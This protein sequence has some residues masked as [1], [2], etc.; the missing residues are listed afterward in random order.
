MDLSILIVS[1]KTKDYLQKCL[2]SIFHSTTKYSFE[3]ILV[4]NNSQDGTR[5]MLLDFFPNI[6]T[7]YNEENT[8]FAIAMN[9]AYRMSTGRYVM[10][11]NP[12]AELKNDSI[13]TL[14]PYL[15]G[16]P[17][18]GMVG[19]SVENTDGSIVLP[20]TEFPLI[21]LRS[22][23]GIFPKKDVPLKKTPQR[24]E[25]IWGSGIT[26]RRE[27]LKVDSMFEELSFLFGEEYHLAQLIK[28]QGKE[29]WINPEIRT[30]HHGSVTFKSDRQ[31]LKM[32]SMLLEANAYRIRKVHFGLIPAKLSAFVL[33]IDS[34]A[35]YI[36]VILGYV[37]K[38]KGS[39]PIASH[40][41]FKY[42]VLTTTHL[43]IFTKGEKFSIEINNRARRYFNGI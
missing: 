13:D 21:Y 40:M 18:I 32:A 31:K 25:W 2:A 1:Y 7:V 11:F 36:R 24:V 26:V 34:L 41:M 14:I 12:D 23:K 17:Q 4:D 9:Q 35:L 28:S 39:D 37:V 38:L 8:G 10:T 33:M 42:W 20:S 30:V 27:L 43:N 29:I 16:N 6:T 5:E 15:D 19:G 3:I 22:F